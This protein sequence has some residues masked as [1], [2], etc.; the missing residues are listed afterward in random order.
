MKAHKTEYCIVSRRSG[1]DGAFTATGYDWL[2]VYNSNNEVQ[3]S[4]QI[5]PETIVNIK[6]WADH[7]LADVEVTNC[8]TYPTTPN[9][10]F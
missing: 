10:I 7:V 5:S 8:D 9:E 2:V 1:R 3:R 6:D 4:L